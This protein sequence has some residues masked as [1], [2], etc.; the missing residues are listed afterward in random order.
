MHG[1]R[2]RHFLLW[3]RQGWTRY[4]AEL[5]FFSGELRIRLCRMLRSRRR[6]TDQYPLRFMHSKSII[7]VTGVRQGQRR[8]IAANVDGAID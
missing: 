8:L 5:T 1:H 7:V 4:R 6:L 3:S 2:D